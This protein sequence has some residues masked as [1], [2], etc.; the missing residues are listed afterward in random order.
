ME[1]RAKKACWVSTMRKSQPGAANFLIWRGTSR[2][3]KSHHRK[4][5][6]GFSCPLRAEK[7]DRLPSGDLSLSP[8]KLSAAGAAELAKEGRLSAPAG[9]RVIPK[10][11]SRRRPL[12]GPGLADALSGRD[13]DR[14]TLF[15]TLALLSLWSRT[16]SA[17]VFFHRR[18]RGETSVFKRHRFSSGRSAGPRGP[19]TSWGTG[20]WVRGFSRRVER[21]GGDEEIRGIRR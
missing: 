2:V 18:S 10:A 13:R 15:T 11:L 9:G 21:E 17:Y 8:E 16:R 19:P 12:R 4:A 14:R 3:F 6:L 1:A 7:A 20:G 5:R